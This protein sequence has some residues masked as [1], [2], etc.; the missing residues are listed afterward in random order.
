MAQYEREL[1]R[2]MQS[3]IYDANRRGVVNEISLG[4]CEKKRKM[5]EDKLNNLRVKLRVL[6]QKLQLVSNKIWSSR[7]I[8]CG[9]STELASSPAIVLPL[10]ASDRS[11]NPALTL[12]IRILKS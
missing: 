3:I 1:K 12:P 10:R 4:Q 11:L 9:K 5:T 7:N 2:K 8:L 6:L